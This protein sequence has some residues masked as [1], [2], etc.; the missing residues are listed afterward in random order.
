MENASVAD[1]QHRLTDE[2]DYATTE[3]SKVGSTLLCS[4]CQV[5]FTNQKTFSE[6]KSKPGLHF[7][8][9]RKSTLRNAI[10]G[11]RLCQEL[12]CIPYNEISDYWERVAREQG[13]NKA[14]SLQKSRGWPIEPWKSELAL[15]EPRGLKGKTAASDRDMHFSLKGDPKIP[16]YTVTLSKHRRLWFAKK[17]DFK[18]AAVKGD[19][20]AE[21]VLSRF[22]NRAIDCDATYNGIRKGLQQCELRHQCQRKDGKI[23]G[24]FGPAFL[25]DVQDVNG[26]VRLYRIGS[27]KYLQYA[28]LTF[29]WGASQVMTTKSNLND[30]LDHIDFDTLS[31]TV[32]DAILVTRKLYLKYLWVD[33]LC[34][35][36][37]SEED[38]LAQTPLLGKI[39]GNAYVSI[40]ANCAKTCNAGFLR[41]VGVRTRFE[42]PYCAESGSVGTVSLT[43][44]EPR[45]PGTA[46]KL[47][48]LQTRAWAYQELCLSGRYI[49]YNKNEVMWTCN[50]PATSTSGVHGWTEHV[51]QYSGRDLTDPC[52]K[53]PGIS[54]LAEHY[55]IHMPESKYLAGIFS[56]ETHHQL[57]WYAMAGRRLTRPQAWRA[58]S[59][60]PL[61]VDGIIEQWHCWT[62]KTKGKPFLVDNNGEYRADFEIMDSGV[63]ALSEKAPFGRVVSGFI[64]VKGRLMRVNKGV[65]GSI[66]SI[67]NI[68]GGLALP[69]RDDSRKPPTGT[70]YFDTVN[71]FG[72]RIASADSIQSNHGPLS[73]NTELA[74]L[75]ICK[76]KVVV[77]HTDSDSNHTTYTIHRWDA[78]LVLA[79][80]ENGD[81][82]RVGHFI[83]NKLNV[84]PSSQKLEVVRIV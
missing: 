70:I 38:K 59:W 74:C 8:R 37:D 2:A 62:D 69:M 30:H 83:C 20:A 44:V 7:T 55:S 76:K 25:V 9:S 19:P 33:N 56:A 27:N 18:T 40:F 22:L 12:L 75:A 15:L 68:L 29:V 64:W 16:P 17:M 28:A 57:C 5:L 52:D 36:Q 48:Y 23:G 31:Q 1:V 42:I 79:K 11:C 47:Q 81:Y 63:E 26:T 41:E 35:I 32:Q 71:T 72:N 21:D 49:A 65:L 80:L 84:F 53:L 39:F 54:S 66:D 78:G 67:G 43:A 34:I 46:G 51:H 24:R 13:W 10:D 61:A 60:S 3:V 73:V 77:T 82:H 14:T 58:P 4:D 6:L 45:A 50:N